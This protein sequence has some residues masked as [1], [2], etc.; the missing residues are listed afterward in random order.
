MFADKP[1]LSCQRTN[2]LKFDAH[3]K[4]L[5]K[6]KSLRLSERSSLFEFCDF[7]FPDVDECKS[8]TAQCTQICTKTSDS[9]ECSCN[10]GYELDEDGFTCRG[11][12]V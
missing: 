2:Y 6:S 11:N 8:G 4:S 5:I 1:V 7:I 9:Y 3:G 12:D 10:E